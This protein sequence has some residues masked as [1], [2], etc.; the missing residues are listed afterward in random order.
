MG[1]ALF[2][3]CYKCQNR[4]HSDPMGYTGEAMLQKPLAFSQKGSGEA[5]EYL[6]Q[7]DGLRP[8]EGQRTAQYSGH[9][10]T[11]APRPKS[12]KVRRHPGPGVP[13][14]VQILKLATWVML[15]QPRGLP[16][17][18][19]PHT[20]PS[21]TGFPKLHTYR[22]SVVGTCLSNPTWCVCIMCPHSCIWVC[23]IF[24]L[25]SALGNVWEGGCL[26]DLC[27]TLLLLFKNSIVFKSIM[28][29]QPTN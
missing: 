13:L 4:A 29:K 23:T 22:V 28:K 2:L 14:E 21:Q 15:A 19:W 11:W 25:N 7:G 9:G 6:K 17:S 27:V 26:C 16:M 18:L 10:G 8:R 24:C 3:E 5:I 12:L 20:D 1:H